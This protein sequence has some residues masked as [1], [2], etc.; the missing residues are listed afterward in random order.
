VRPHL[1]FCS[2]VWGPHCEK[3][4]NK[5]DMIQRRAA[6]FVMGEYRRT[7]SVSDM[8]QS[9]NWSSLSSRRCTARLS[10][11]YKIHNRLIPINFDETLSPMP[12]LSTRNSHIHS[13]SI[14]FSSSDAHKYSFLPRTIR[15]WNTLPQVVVD[16]PTLES[17]KLA[18][19][20][21]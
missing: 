1:E 6:R 12:L 5:I 17:F 4:I 20:K 18:L 2:S 16:M 15:D 19:S 3:Y 21:I 7:H 14:P 9:L 11:F 8:L 10:I 13:Y